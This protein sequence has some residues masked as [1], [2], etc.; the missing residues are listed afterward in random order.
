MTLENLSTKAMTGLGTFVIV[1]LLI[2]AVVFDSWTVVETG[3]R[4]IEVR[5][6]KVQGMLDEGFHFVTP[7]ITKVVKMPVRETKIQNKVSCYSKDAQIVETTFSVNLFPNHT[8]VIALYK[9]V[10]EKYILKLA[11][12]ILEASIKEVFGKYKAVDLITNRQ[13]AAQEIKM[14]IVERLSEKKLNVVNFELVNIDFDDEFEKAVKN[15]VIAVEES[16]RSENLLEKAKNDKAIKITEAEAEAESMRI[17]ANAL[18]TNRNLIEYEAIKKWNGKLPEYMMGNS[19][20]FINL[21]K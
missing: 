6:G 7:F 20:P 11:P 16:K 9:E 1:T 12:Q 8:E 15:K 5:L 3:F 14:S 4:G 21:K 17:R 18:Q 13:Q 19:M 2:I 10:G